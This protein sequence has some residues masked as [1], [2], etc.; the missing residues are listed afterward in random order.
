MAH[1]SRTPFNSLSGVSASRSDGSG[2]S[3]ASS[4][5]KLVH[6]RRMAFLKNGKTRPDNEL[7]AAISSYNKAMGEIL[8]GLKEKIDQYPPEELKVLTPQKLI[9]NEVDSIR[10]LISEASRRLRDSPA[11]K[12]AEE[13]RKIRNLMSMRHSTPHEGTISK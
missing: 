12:K 1:F 5:S 4:F 13:E 6:Q 10:C 9:L 2:A 7:A 3:T 8:E 11:M